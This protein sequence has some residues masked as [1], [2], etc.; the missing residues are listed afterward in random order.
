MIVDEEQR[1]GVAH[2]ERL[3]Q[4]KKVDVLTMT[5]TPIPRTLHMA[6]GG[7]RDMS[8]IETPP[9]DRLAIQTNVVKFRPLV[10]GRAIRNELERGGQ[11]YFV[12]NRV[13]TISAI[14]ICC[15]AGPKARVVVGHGQMAEVNSKQ[16]A[17]F[18]RTQVRRPGRN[19]HHRERPGYSGLTRSSS[20]GPIDWAIPAVPAARSCGPSE[21]RAYAYLLIPP[22]TPSPRRAA[23]LKALKEFSD[24]GCGFRIAALDLE[25]RGAGNFLGGEQTD[26]SRRRLRN[27]L[28]MLERTVRELKGEGCEESCAPP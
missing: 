5:A 21:R 27:L 20:T 25:I 17:R 2:K 28:A 24:L 13:E 3:K 16:Y 15:A 12:H 1:F 8:V 9:R 19:D 6:L 4:I 11:V 10:I 26:T 22:T 18:H 14:G 23:R 7:L